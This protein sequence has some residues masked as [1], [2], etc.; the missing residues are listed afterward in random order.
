MCTIKSQN[1][2]VKLSF[3]QGLDTSCEEV[4]LFQRS[5]WN[6]TYNLSSVWPTLIALQLMSHTSDW[7]NQNKLGVQV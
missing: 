1:S 4:L 6:L 7:I 5:E 2:S 3:T